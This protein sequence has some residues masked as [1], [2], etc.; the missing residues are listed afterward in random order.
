M[1]RTPGRRSKKWCDWQCKARYQH[2]QLKA[3]G[4]TKCTVSFPACQV[5]DAIFAGRAGG[6]RTRWA[7]CSDECARLLKN[8]RERQRH[9]TLAEAQQQA[10][11]DR[12][13]RRRALTKGA[14]AEPFTYVEVF[15]RDGWVCGLCDG[16]VDRELKHP[17]PMCASLDHVVPLSLGGHHVLSNVQCAHLV[18]NIRKGARSVA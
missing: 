6:R 15:D 1:R 3:A 17:D 9:A 4:P 8:E 13:A 12:K 14:D 5:C 7:T 10:R 16:P 18:C 11:L 2:A